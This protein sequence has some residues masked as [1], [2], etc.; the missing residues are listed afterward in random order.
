MADALDREYPDLR[1]DQILS[2]GVYGETVAGYRYTILAEK[3]PS[4]DDRKT[5]AA[6]ADEEQGHKQRLQRLFERHYPD[7][8]FYLSEEDKALVVAGPRL[9][10]VRDLDDYRQIMK[11]A[12]DT[13]LMTARF[14]R[15]M[16][17]RSGNSEIRA[18]FEQMA[19][20]SFDHHRRLTDLARQ[21]GFLPP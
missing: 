6:I 5:F 4:E 9:I 16:S 15:A 3:L 1:D 14:Y 20:E 11:L 21:R 17:T 8:S 2:I 13:E 7:R 19:D 10:N 12:L 18:L